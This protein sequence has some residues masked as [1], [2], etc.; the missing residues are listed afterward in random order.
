[1]SGIVDWFD[2]AI[3][4]LGAPP[5]VITEG[6]ILDPVWGRDR[7]GRLRTFFPATGLM[8]QLA[9]RIVA[10]RSV[11]RLLSVGCRVDTDL[12]VGNRYVTLR[13]EVFVSRDDAWL[14]WYSFAS[15]QA[16]IADSVATYFWAPGLPNASTGIGAFPNTGAL[17][18][19][20]FLTDGRLLSI[21]VLGAQVGDIV[22]EVIFEVEEWR[23]PRG[24]GGRGT[25]PHRCRSRRGP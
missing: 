19:G 10:P 16:L 3:K 14:A 4:H 9:P 1:M 20:P 13:L 22:D 8:P 15:T 7:V 5:I 23:L 24:W 2:R 11:W 12:N 25:C 6:G 21:E 18:E 17:P